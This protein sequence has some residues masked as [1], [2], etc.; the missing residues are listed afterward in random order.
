[1]S[2]VL[3]R[4][5]RLQE[6]ETRA[7]DAQKRIAEL[8]VLIA[9]LDAKLIA[10]HD[11]VASAKQGVADNQNHRRTLDRDLIAA[12]QRLSKYKEQLMA[13]KTNHEYHAMQHQIAAAEAEVGRIEELV[14]INMVEAD[15]TSA[16]LKAAEGA[17]KKD[18]GMLARERAGLETED[19]EKRRVL[20]QTTAP[21]SRPRSTVARAIC[22]TGC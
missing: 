16:T 17:L 13:V 2:P 8:P 21:R 20:E 1:M 15:E 6:I 4:L 12:Q 11:A 10:A 14:I 22:S 7:A 19:T 5:I 18:E 9:A 3:E